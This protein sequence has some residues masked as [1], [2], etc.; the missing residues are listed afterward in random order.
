MDPIAVDLA[1]SACWLEIDGALPIT[2]M[3][4]NI[5]VGSVLAGDLPPRHAEVFPN[6]PLEVP[7]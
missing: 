3:D 7:A 1:K 2:F 4:R 6:S 5:I